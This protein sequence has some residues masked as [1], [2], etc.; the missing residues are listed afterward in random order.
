MSVNVRLDSVPL[1]CSLPLIRKLF[2]VDAWVTQ[3]TV[4]IRVCVQPLRNLYPIPLIR[5]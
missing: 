4:A 3:S 5:S 2:S 1:M